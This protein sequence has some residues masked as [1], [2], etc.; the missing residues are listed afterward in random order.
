MLKNSIKK[1]I[2]S[3]TY[4]CTAGELAENV[5]LQCGT[6]L[7]ENT[8]L[9]SHIVPYGDT[10]VAGDYNIAIESTTY[11]FTLTNDMVGSNDGNRGLLFNDK[12]KELIIVYEDGEEV[13]YVIIGYSIGTAIGTNLVVE[14][15]SDFNFN[16]SDF[17]IE[18]NQFV[19]GETC[20][21]VIKAIAMLSYGWAKIGWDNKLYFE[22]PVSMYPL[23]IQN[24]LN[25]I[26][27]TKY[28]DL[29][30]QK[31][32]YGPVNRVTIGYSDI[33]GEKSSVS[34]DG[35][36]NANGLTE[37]ALFD[38]PLT[39]NQTLRETALLTANS[40]FGLEYYPIKVTTIG[41]PWL[42]SNDMIKIIDMESNEKITI[43]LDITISYDGHIKTTMESYAL[44]KTETEYLYN[45]TL[46]Q[47]LKNTQ[48]I[49]DKQAQTITQVVET[50]TDLEQ[51]TTQLILD[52]DKIE[53]EIGTIADIT[54][55]VDGNG[56][57]SADGI[58]E[59]E[60]IYLRITPNGTDVAYLYPRNNLYPSDSLYPLSRD[61]V[62]TNTTDSTVRRYTLPKDLYAIGT[63]KDEFVL[64]YDKQECYVIHRIGLDSNGDKYILTT[65]N[66]EYVTYP[67]IS[68][69]T[70]DYVISVE[71]FPTAYIY[72]RLMISNIYT[73]QFATKV[74]LN[75]K[76]T[77]T[78]NDINLEVSKKV[79]NTEVIS[80]INQT[81]ETIT[82]NANKINVAGVLSVLGTSGST[83]ING[84]N[85]KTGTINASLVSVTNLNASNIKTGTLD[86]SIINVT[87]L[88]AS[89][90]KT[91][92]LDASI[93]NVTNLNAS[94]IK[95]GT[96]DASIINVTNL[97]ASNIK[98]GSL[99]ASIINVTNLNASNIK[100]GSLQSANYVLNTSGTKINLSDGTI[101]TKNFKL[102]STGVVNASSGSFSGTVS[103]GNLTATGGNIAG[104][105]IGTS[106]ISNTNSSG[107]T[108]ILANGTSAN[109]D[110]LVVTDG[111]NYPFFLRANG[112]LSAS[113][114]NI[115]GTINSSSGI[116]GGW[117]LTGS[118]LYAY[119][120]NATSYLYNNGNVVFGG[121][122]GYIKFDS[123][124]VRI[125]TASR[126]LISDRYG[127]NSMV[128]ANDTIAIRCFSGTLQLNSSVGVY[129]NSVLLASGS[130]KKM[131]KNIKKLKQDEKDLIYKEVRDLPLY[132][133]DYKDKYSGQKDNYGVIIEDFEN[134]LL[135]KIL[136]VTKDEEDKNVKHFFTRRP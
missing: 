100:T 58:N 68:L 32:K 55:T 13:V 47:K 11:N 9:Y 103:T 28:Y 110:V 125:T 51:K 104:W 29:S 87:N 44:T 73:N 16:N 105:S 107:N 133:Y 45:G 123:D 60:P 80:K 89:N 126:M 102:S 75:S 135:G 4:P 33:D 12:T 50:T 23:S 121:D 8:N 17:V 79:G 25:I 40:I 66:T 97:N 122:Y 64:D 39:Y 54:T 5:A 63:I 117:G 7:G 22:S 96:L 62:F 113:N 67:M 130:S 136:H 30:M 111:T 120:T 99:D 115:S 41:H 118:Y 21:D 112:Y 59:S 34:D 128:G 109:Q 53:A 46:D 10:L 95:T 72:V 91:G 31:L 76:I 20:R 74:E 88:N 94:N 36:I 19:N 26:D 92:T 129:A 52:I 77:Q 127:E 106:T 18:S 86:A 49:V 14:H 42:N 56:T 69:T 134:N 6:T 61:I 114:V 70:G 90:I 82:I 24:E 108:V 78:A 84:S 57:V 93:I 85:I 43:P 35:S 15:Y 2:D 3:V 65:P 132:A 116:I 131:K 81:A 71:S 38:N 98:T 124:P 1:Y 83:I 37:I 48:I 119:G 101:D 27:N